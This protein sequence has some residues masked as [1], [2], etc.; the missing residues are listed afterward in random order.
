MIKKLLAI[1]SLLITSNTFSKQI[2]GTVINVIDGD[3]IKILSTDQ[4]EYKIKLYGIDAPELKQY[5][6]IEAKETLEE[7]ILN[8]FVTVNYEK[9]GFYKRIIGK[10]FILPPGSSI[11]LKMVRFGMAWHYKKYSKDEDLAFAEAA[12]QKDKWGLWKYEDAVPPWEWRKEYKALAKR[13]CPPR[14]V[15]LSSIHSPKPKS[16]Y[17]YSLNVKTNVRHNETCTY[18]NNSDNDVAC[19]KDEGKKCLRCGG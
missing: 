12:A 11:N 15:G 17:S 13:C 7:M 5:F 2:K 16:E 3:T 4:K 18:F 9:R 8:K 19:L 6:G 14:R 1:L 10:V